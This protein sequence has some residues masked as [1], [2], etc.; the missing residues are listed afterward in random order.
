[1][2][3]L[4]TVAVITGSLVTGN[5]VRTT[6]I[7]RVAERL[8]DT[9][10]IIFSRNA[11]LEDRILE[12]SVLKNGVKGRLLTNGFVSW[13]GK[14]I[15]VFVWGV[16]DLPIA[17]GT[18]RVNSALLDEMGTKQPD[19]IVLRLP[20]A[21]LVPSGSLF[22]TENYTTGMRLDFDGT[23][24]VQD[25]G[26][27]S[28]KNEQ[29]IPL[30]IFV[31][32]KELAE[33]MQIE[34]KIN[35]LLANKKI[36]VEAFEQVWDYTISGL[37]V[38]RMDDF[39]EI[40]SDRIFM[41]EEVVSSICQNNQV[42]NRLFSYLVNT[43][44]KA[45]TSN[46]IEQS[47]PSNTIEHSAPSK[48]AKQVDESIPYS[49]VTAMDSY[50]GDVLQ[51]DEIILSDYAANRMQAKKGDRIKITYF[52]SKD[53]KTLQ[54]R[55]VSLL[56]KKI[57]PLSELFEDKTLSAEFPGLS[58]VESC[59]DWD[60]DLPINMDLI[61]KEDEKYWE[62]YRTTPKAIIAYHAI[63]GDWSNTYGS[64]TAIRI[65]NTTSG[66]GD[67]TSA[68][69][70]E[71]PIS[72][73]DD[74]T[75][76]SRLENPLPNLHELHTGMFGIQIIYPRAAGIMAAKNGV[77]FSGLFL[78]L[79]IFII[80]SAILLMIVPLS[81][82]LYRRSNE[83]ALLKA[84]GFSRKRITR[85]IWMES[86][87][88]TLVA[89]VAGVLVGI[90]YTSLIMWL[91]GSFWR[92]A[93]HTGGFSVYP[94]MATVAIGSLVG[95][96][97]SFFTLYRTI[98]RNLK[99]SFTGIK[100]QHIAVKNKRTITILS[101][102][103]SIGLIGLN[104][105]FLHDVVLFVIA[106]V[107]LLATAA[108]WGDYIICRNG[109]ASDGGFNDKKMIWSAL[110]AHKKQAMWSFLAL[111]TGVFIV[112]S[113]GL[114]RKG[115][116]NSAQLRAGTGGYT[117]WCESSVP[118]YH[119]MTTPEGRA[120]L[121]LT[122]LPA[123]VQILQCLRFSADD[124]SC[125]NLNK[126]TTP[127]VLGIDM[128]VLAESEFVI[129]KNIFSLNGK[130]V[131]LRLQRHS[132][133]DDNK[134]VYPALVD[135]TVLTWSLGL[136]LGDTLFY[137]GDKGQTVAIQLAG[138]LPNT[139]FQGNILIDKKF[140]SEIWKETTGSE[141]F[142]LQTGETGKE[143]IKTLLS[144]AMNEYGV[145]VTTTNDRLQ[146]FNSVTDT[147]LTIFMTLG[148]IGLLLGI[149]SFIIVVRKSLATR[150]DE[151]NLY[152]TIGFTNEKIEKTLYREN[153]I[154]PLY[155]ITSGV[156]CALAGIGVSYTNT[157]I[158]MWLMA[159]LFTTAF[160]GCVIVFVKKSVKSLLVAFQK[161]PLNLSNGHSIISTG[162]TVAPISEK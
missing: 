146:Q 90:I 43:I 132:D 108:L 51:P 32:R 42:S 57:V 10:T 29:T 136:N 99:E 94:D 37:S 126:V 96:G 61:T 92:G 123:D 142:L 89:T 83:I 86:A 135:A 112:F 106:G 70:L 88:V 46:A 115:F 152:K 71:K 121:S 9:E 150:R 147:Y 44:E 18:A 102:I 117:L 63:A 139:I 91:L 12:S 141:V 60:S 138:T 103:L 65:N 122:T 21:G 41:Q 20:A 64:A 162:R 5:S 107:T 59:T 151:I 28:L 52:T 119:N 110:Y 156:L 127:T 58:D 15:P 154:V 98:K 53:L 125:L 128:N 124:A 82:M 26:H 68:I 113:V 19:A 36:A 95:I 133:S 111:A 11:F 48:V 31:N 160:V 27:I 30:N 35:L 116:E 7:N 149:M 47:A 137:T 62:L 78:A 161:Y 140:F 45:A 109:A 75:P 54:T 93:T 2:A 24:S 23:V 67:K 39:T 143:D 69:R 84:T 76:A 120:K 129:E 148:G 114:N 153:L 1:M 13:N 145:R 157:G 155:A 77:D 105:L 66:F 159:M 104:F 87:P 85:L 6:L 134:K 118:V 73:S 74:N 4:I 55:S 34:R 40:T 101:F 50:K 17:K 3:A 33:V 100:K 14:L 158:Y 131:F 144:Q 8:G 81:E 79:G 97:L 22:V 49:F 72:T 16:D 80:I 38:V 25:G 56:V 130:D